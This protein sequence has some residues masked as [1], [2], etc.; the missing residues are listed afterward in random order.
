MSFVWFVAVLLILLVS[1]W[2]VVDFP[3]GSPSNIPSVHLI[4]PQPSTPNWY[5]SSRPT[6]KPS[7]QPTVQPIQQP[8]SKPT[9]QPV[10][11]PSGPPSIQPS[12]VSLVS[13][14]RREMKMQFT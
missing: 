7:S 14:S 5:H 8:S 1:S 4:L 2:A 6:V 10:S 12:P 11:D 13:R 3:S 9:R